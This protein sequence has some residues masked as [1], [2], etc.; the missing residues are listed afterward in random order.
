[1]AIR[2]VPHE[3]SLDPMFAPIAAAEADEQ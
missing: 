3:Q 1:L 2:P